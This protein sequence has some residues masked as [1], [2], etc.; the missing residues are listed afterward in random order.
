MVYGEM[1]IRHDD[2][3]GNL[4]ETIIKEGDSF[5]FPPYSIHQEEALTDC[6]VIE[7]STPHFNDRVR[8]ESEYGLQEQNGLSTTHKNDIQ[9]M[10][11][12]KFLK[13]LLFVN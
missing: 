8:V 2:G 4:I 10:Q 3:F 12:F 5:R 9:T 13:K 1:I 11:M 6:L 7:A